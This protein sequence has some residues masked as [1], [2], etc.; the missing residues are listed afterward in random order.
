MAT[1][2][3]GSALMDGALLVIAANEPCPQPQTAEHLAVLDIVGIKNIVIVQNKIDLVSE[4]Q[5][6]KN[7]QQ[8][9]AFV[10]DT[11]AENAPI[12]PVSAQHR[13]G[14]DMLI[15]TIE[16]TIKTPPRDLTKDPKMYIARSFDVNKPG[17]PIEKLTGGIVGGGL[18]E[19]QLKVGQ[20]IE[21]RPGLRRA[22]GGP[23]EAI[24]TKIV[25]MIHGSA[26]VNEG[27]PGGL[28]AL[29]TLLDP[30][31]TKADSLVGNIVG[32]PGKLPPV[33]NELKLEMHLL[34]RVVGLEE[35]EKAQIRLPIKG[36]QLM[37]NVGTARTV[38]ICEEAGKI[39]KFKLKLPVCA[40][41]GDKVALSKLISGRWRLIGWGVIQK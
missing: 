27:K 5:A 21:L 20:E 22:Q 24:K 7:Y 15:E 11:V 35:K 8:I 26:K 23:W 36:E 38:G 13:A 4:E 39:S 31:I 17:T 2:L 28:L 40:S 12:V 14:L 37:M 29:G 41:A 30:Y 10:K 3:S 9:K 32:L 16:K 25:S 33:W 6:I 18:V 19:G 34:T 1:V